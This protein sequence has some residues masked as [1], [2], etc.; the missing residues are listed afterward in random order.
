MLVES[1]EVVLDIN[2]EFQKKR[3]RKKIGKIVRVMRFE[4]TKFR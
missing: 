3:E 2:K 1:V 4:V